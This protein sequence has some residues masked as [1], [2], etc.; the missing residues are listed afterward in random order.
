[1]VCPGCH[2]VHPDGTR[3]CSRCGVYLEEPM[4]GLTIRDEWIRAVASIHAGD[5]DNA[6]RVLNGILKIEPD[7][8]VARTYLGLALLMAGDLAGAISELGRAREA[9]LPLTDLLLGMSSRAAGDPSG[10][11]A[12]FRRSAEGVPGLRLALH[13]EAGAGL[14]LDDLP[15]AAAAYERLSVLDPED[16][17]PHFWLG[18]I[19][20]RRGRLE[21]A[22]AALERALGRE[23]DLREARLLLGEVRLSKGDAP[24]A[25]EAFEEVLARTPGEARAH[26]RLGMLLSEA[27]AGEG[28]IRHL[29]SAVVARPDHFESH[30]QLALLYYGERQDLER[31]LAE[32]DVAMAIEPNDPAANLILSELKFLSGRG[33]SGG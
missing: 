32:L 21:D 28:A 24:G 20:R 29:E 1:M 11:V 6:V 31:A 8:A 3:Y 22:E 2:A 17:I 13:G 33:E 19:H 15:S 30:F 23:P 26:Y 27:G 9:G 4:P 5:T 10:A 18:V 12:A 16:P 7:H 25:R 14:D